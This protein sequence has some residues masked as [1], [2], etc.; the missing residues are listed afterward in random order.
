MLINSSSGELIDE[1]ALSEAIEN[2]GIRVGL[3]VYANEP[4]ATDKSF[5]SVLANHSDV[6]GTHH[7]GASTTQAQ[8][9]VANGVL[10]VIA[11]YQAD[12]L[13]NCVN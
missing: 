1:A 8:I 10:D 6:C 4:G 13:I 3:D 11:S 9:A 12:E 5:D 2:K 7:I